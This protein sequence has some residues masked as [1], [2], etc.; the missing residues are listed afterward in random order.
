MALRPERKLW[1]RS[2][3][4]PREAVVL[5]RGDSS[6]VVGRLAADELASEARA[7]YAARYPGS[8]SLLD[9]AALVVFEAAA[10]PGR[11]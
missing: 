9:A 8:A 2:F 10:S 7:A 11:R 6:A 3:V 1:W 5:L 4:E